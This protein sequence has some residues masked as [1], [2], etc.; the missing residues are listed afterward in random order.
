[1]SFLSNLARRLK[2]LLRGA[3]LEDGLDEEMR[4]HMELRRDQL[5]ANGLSDDEATAAARRRFGNPLQRREDSV[6]VWGWRW[7]EQLSQ[8]LRFAIRTL[9]RNPGFTATVVLTLTLATGATTSI[10]SVVNGVL[11]RPLPFADP[12][13]LVQIYGRRWA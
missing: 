8:D 6:D 5:R 10:F 1:M 7:L 12:D 4:L 13:R 11:L 9:R 2:A 3:R